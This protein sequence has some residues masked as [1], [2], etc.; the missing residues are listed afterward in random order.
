MLRGAI[1]LLAL[2]F[3]LAIIETHLRCRTKDAGVYIPGYKIASRDRTDGRKGGGSLIYFSK[4]LNAHDSSELSSDSS[5]F[6][7]TVD[8]FNLQTP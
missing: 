4:K 5:P 7:T 2:K 1:I 3:V 6:P 8:W